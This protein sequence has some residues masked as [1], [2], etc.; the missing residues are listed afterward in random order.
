[1]TS[2][3]GTIVRAA[4]AAVLL[5]A[6]VLTGVAGAQAVPEVDIVRTDLTEFP[7]VQLAVAVSGAAAAEELEADDLEVTENGEP[8][9]LELT[10]LSDQSLDVVLTIDVSASMSGEPLGQ[11]KVA[12]LEFIDELPSQARV[13]II[14][15]GGSA[16]LRSGFT[17]DRGSSRDAVNALTDG[18]GTALYDGVT[19][20]AE[21]V[22]ASDADRS[23]VVVLTDGADTESDADL[24][25]AS[26]AVEGAQSEFYVVSLET[27]EIDEAALSDLADAAGGRVV[28]ADDPDALSAAYVDL[29]QR[30]VNQYGLTFESTTEEPTGEYRVTVTSSGDSA[31]TE[32]ALPGRAGGATDGDGEAVAVQVDPLV[33]EGSASPLQQGWALWLGAAFLAVALGVIGYVVAPSGEER[34]RRR[35]LRSDRAPVDDG[36]GAGERLVDSVRDRATRVADRAVERSEQGGS[37]DASLDRAGLIMRAGEF[38]ALVFGAAVIA[39]FLL[40]LLMGVVGLLIGILVPVLGAPAFLRVLATRRNAKFADQ[41]ADTLLQ[42]AGALRAGFGLGQV[43]DQISE[44]MDAP[45]GDEFQRAVL[46]TRLGRDVEDALGG[47]A[48]R[49][50]NEDFVWVVDAI[51]VHRR[52]GGDL[53]QI[54]ERVSETIRARNRLRRQIQALTAEGRLSAIV[55]GSL[56]IAMGLILYASNPDYL[57]PLFSRTIG[58]IALGVGVGLLAIGVLWLRKLID[59]EL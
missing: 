37:I 57:E 44:E 32:I 46:E 29:G 16:E 48:T 8:V 31:T 24:E 11:A 52:V 56:P 59:V 55:L 2:P 14:G 49:M 40:Y 28:P 13:A 34:T 23:A 50:Q 4:S 35:A 22:N 58:W 6:V 1:M 17:T 43:V 5:L 3:A 18:G 41:L 39:A 25:A 33:T 7:T 38:V 51:R 30:I 53:S 20:S 21:Q 45:I 12:A 19:L 26:S 36:R 9:D 42:M 10:P 47:I 54:L 27:E 15:F